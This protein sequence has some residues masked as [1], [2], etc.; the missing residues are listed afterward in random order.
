MMAGWRTRGGPLHRAPRRAPTLRSA[1][2]PHE[3]LMRKLCSHM[4]RGRL[5]FVGMDGGRKLGPFP[6]DSRHLDGKR[7]ALLRFKDNNNNPRP[8]C[9]ERNGK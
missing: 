4:T 8:A 9:R 2:R 1:G 6:H 7:H 3:Y 5:K